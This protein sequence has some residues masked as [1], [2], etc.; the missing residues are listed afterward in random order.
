MTDEILHEDCDAG[1]TDELEEQD[2]T[3][4]GIGA[5]AGGLEAIR[6]FVHHL[7]GDLAAAYVVVQHLSPDHH[8]LL[9]TLVDRETD[10][11]VVE[12]TDGLRVERNTVY[13]TPPSWDV[14]IDGSKL[15]LQ[16]P[17]QH[18][19][20]PRPSVD[21]F[22]KS[23]AESYG[24]RVVG[25][26]FSGTGSDGSYGFQA[27]Q[28]A[29]GVTIAQDDQ[30]AKYDGMPL[31]AV[32]TGC[33]DLVLPPAE[34]AQK[35]QRIIALPRDL[36]AIRPSDQ[37]QN[38]LLDLMQIVHSATRVDFQ[39]YKQ[40]T[41]RRRIERRMAAVGVNSFREYTNLCR[42]SPAEVRALFKDLLISVTR[43]FRDPAEFEQLR[44]V[45]GEIVDNAG[46]EPI[47]V[48]VPGCA[49]GEEAYS[50]AMHFAEAL[51]SKGEISKD[52]L[53]IFATDID[54]AALDTARQGTYPLSISGDI[55]SDLFAR[56]FTVSGDKI[57]IDPALKKAVV[58]SRHDLCTDPPFLNIDLICCRNVIIY[59][60]RRLQERVLSRLNYALA[61]KGLLFLG[62]SESV[63]IHGNLFEA[64]DHGSHLYRKHARD[65]LSREM[66]PDQSRTLPVAAK[67]SAG[68]IEAGATNEKNLLLFESL[69]QVVG[70]DALLLQSDLKIVRVFGNVSRYSSLTD[71]TRLRFDVSMLRR[72]LSAA[73]RGLVGSALRQ[74]EKRSVTQG[75]LKD[76]PDHVV[77]MDCY[78]IKAPG[79]EEDYALL[80][81]RRL[82]RPIEVKPADRE[83]LSTEAIEHI[84]T[85]ES[86]I[87]RL[88]DEHQ[89]STEELETTNE[90]LQTTIEEFQ[91]TNEELQSTN[92]EIET[93]N[94]ELQS[95]N[96]EL[97]TVNEELQI[98]TYEMN[99]LNDEQAAV[100][101]SVLA[102]LIIVDVSMHV[103][104]MNS[105]AAKLIDVSR[106]LD[107]PHLSQ[108]RF[109]DGFLS[110]SEFCN[111]ALSI[112]R[113]LSRRVVSEDQVY[114]LD[115]APYFNSDGQLR[116]A[117]LMFHKAPAAL[118]E[119]EMAP[120][121]P[122][123]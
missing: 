103:T 50:V 43:F 28:A 109:P 83:G 77:Q 74:G 37:E 6:E 67:S 26:V 8:S 110:I 11:R 30:S 57:Q 24:K 73:A 70:P 47:R 58:F 7:P 53:Q 82:T 64:I 108:C 88:Q 1:R 81:F 36:D 72:E 17:S 75:G 65:R 66:F 76:D 100:L 86:E 68:A 121:L 27:I 99:V 90:E 94:E 79:L 78:P 5:S 116:G 101:E 25:I 46:I 80:A 85:L 122:D 119:A 18:T 112:G 107:R 39:E 89:Q 45:I 33:V 9:T 114:T 19:G 106:S 23:A 97:I 117:T 54:L 113:P 12:V 111:E 98:S 52:V 62:K 29:G 63:S 21:R 22:F 38:P 3:I 84:E 104:K 55:P 2:L 92:E 95:A 105:A 31:A 20:S 16:H 93:S 40:T 115:I 34:I 41:I 44:D 49:T 61:Q 102:P 60:G 96:E 118:P 87:R 56:Y 32:E 120:A 51:G 71:Q 35:L 4:V 91:S 15:L 69:A 14:V 10:L 42:T 48:W 13:V 123:A 59:F